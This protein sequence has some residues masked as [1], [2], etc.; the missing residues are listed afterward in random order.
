MTLFA[1][2][3]KH[4]AAQRIVVKGRLIYSKFKPQTSC[5]PG[6]EHHA[7][8]VTR[9]IALVT[10]ASSG[11]GE[12]LARLLAERGHDLVLVARDRGRLEALAKELEGRVP[13]G[14]VEVLPADLTDADQ[15]ATVEARCH[16]RSAPVDV[17]R[18][19][20]GL[21]YVRAAAHARRRHRGARDPAR[22]CVALVRL[23]HAAAQPRWSS[24]ARAGS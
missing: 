14:R 13:R 11:I 18:E 6:A 21:R 4:S 17:A 24:G 23:T 16:D 10:G 8:G 12:S 5:E 1:C 22:T 2:H 15:L 20:R 9:P 7:G 19:Q 3:P